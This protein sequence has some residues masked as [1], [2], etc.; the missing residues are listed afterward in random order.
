M[1]IG[2]ILD[3]CYHVCRWNLI[4]G[5]TLHW[6]ENKNIRCICLIFSF[7]YEPYCLNISM[8]TVSVLIWEKKFSTATS[9]NPK[10]YKCMWFIKTLWRLFLMTIPF[11]LQYTWRTQ[12]PQFFPTW[13]SETGIHP[14]QYWTCQTC[15][16]GTVLI[17]DS[18]QPSRR[19][20]FYNIR[21]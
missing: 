21:L 1:C 6:A 7:K 15:P 12:M 10:S 5:G 13:G 20:K 4:A 3:G 16:P 2:T 8:S 9:S 19:L 17:R 18:N 14:H 11:S